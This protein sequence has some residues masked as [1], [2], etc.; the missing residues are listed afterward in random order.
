ML[1]WLIVLQKLI[2]VNN[3]ELFTKQG[4]IDN[5][6]KLAARV[7]TLKFPLAEVH[8]LDWVKG[9]N[10]D[11]GIRLDGLKELGCICAGLDLW[12]KVH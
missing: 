12:N 1:T 6:S 9:A 10:G 11:G 4:C 5:S 3:S 8:D 2:I 7:C